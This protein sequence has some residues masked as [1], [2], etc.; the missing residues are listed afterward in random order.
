MPFNWLW[1]LSLSICLNTQ[2]FLWHSLSVFLEEPAAGNCIMGSHQHHMDVPSQPD[3][4][5]KCTTP[6]EVFFWW[7]PLPRHSWCENLQRKAV[8][9]FSLSIARHTDSRSWRHVISLVPVRM[10]GLLPKLGAVGEGRTPLTCLSPDPCDWTV[11]SSVSKHVLFMKMAFFL[12]L[13]YPNHN[14]LLLL[15]P[16]PLH[17]PSRSDPVPFCWV[18]RKQTGF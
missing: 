9:S 5:I 1:I 8:L 13:I 15:L 6:R 14:N 12:A 18:T 16:V 3:F 4:L 11:N 2:I 7:N 17:L 10:W